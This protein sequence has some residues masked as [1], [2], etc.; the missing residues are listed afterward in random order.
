MLRPGGCLALVNIAH[1]T[2][3]IC[4]GTSFATL[5]LTPERMRAALGIA[6]FTEI[7]TREIGAD[8]VASRDQG[9]SRMMLTRARR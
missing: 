2:Q 9:Y 4:N 7:E 3:W 5:C 6:G 1:A 8:D